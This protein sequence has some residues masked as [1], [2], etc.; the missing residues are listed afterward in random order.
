MSREELF[1]GLK[2]L[3]NNLY[4]PENFARRVL[5]MIERMG[6]QIGP[7]RHGH[8]PS[9]IR[10]VEGQAI[11]VI[12][13]LLRRGPKEKRMWK[14]ISEAMAQRPETS[15]MVM[16][17]MFSYA[18]VR[19]LYEADHYWDPA[20]LDRPPFSDPI[21]TVASSAPNPAQQPEAAAGR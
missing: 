18:Q 20:V 15:P 13:K 3:G 12:G 11:G 10:P 19:C 16:M 9:K 4:S 17:S 1:D 21:K 14:E 5:A 8:K 7:F 6:P 2:W